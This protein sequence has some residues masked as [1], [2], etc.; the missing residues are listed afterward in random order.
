MQIEKCIDLGFDVEIDIWHDGK[1]FLLGHDEPLYKVSVAQLFNWQN[2]IWLHCKN[3]EAM[4]ELGHYKGEF[5]YFWHESD[6]YTLTSHGYIW[7]A[8]HSF[9]NGLSDRITTAT[10]GI[11]AEA[12]D[13]EEYYLCCDAPKFFQRDYLGD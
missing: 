13:N 9:K 11:I 10:F 5:N 3:L 7:T 4:E 8:Q 12:Y 6:S 1:Q 2:Y